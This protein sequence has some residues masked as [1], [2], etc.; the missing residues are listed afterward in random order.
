M[1]ITSG[2]NNNCNQLYQDNKYNLQNCLET[3]N[4]Q[5]NKH[6]TNDKLEKWSINSHP[7]LASTLLDDISK[8]KSKLC[9]SLLV[10]KLN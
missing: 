7:K 3:Q 1:R 9:S 10:S 6:F 5:Q 2:N 8:N 4:S